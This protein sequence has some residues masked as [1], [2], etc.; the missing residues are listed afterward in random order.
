M[1][2]S[3]NNN[4]VKSKRK[5]A[6]VNMQHMMMANREHKLKLHALLTLV[7][8]SMDRRLRKT[9]SHPT[10]VARYKTSSCSAIIILISHK[11]T[12]SFQDHEL[13]S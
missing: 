3:E 13:P 5:V 2:I 11:Q 1:I 9:H 6:P 12:R 10:E 8:Y 7:R 4:K